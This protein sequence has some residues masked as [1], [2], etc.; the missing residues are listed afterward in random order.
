MAHANGRHS[1]LHAVAMEAAEREVLAAAYAAANSALATH[2]FGN[3]PEKVAAVRQ[4]VA[5]ITMVGKNN[6]VRIAQ[7]PHYGH[8]AELLTDACVGGSGKQSFAEQSQKRL[9]RL[10]N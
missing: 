5:V 7:R 9:F 4:K 2:D 3:Q 1:G 10:P 6:I 8:L